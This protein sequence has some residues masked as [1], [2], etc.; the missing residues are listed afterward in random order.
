MQSKGEAEEFCQHLSEKGEVFH[1]NTAGVNV[2]Y[3]DARDITTA[4][5]QLLDPSGVCSNTRAGFRQH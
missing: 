2:V 3:L 1:F 4:L 5:K